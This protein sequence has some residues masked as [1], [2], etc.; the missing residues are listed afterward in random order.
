MGAPHKHRCFSRE[1]NLE[2]VHLAQESG[3]NKVDV[4]RQLGIS[5]KLRSRWTRDHRLAP[6]QAFPGHSKL[7]ERD[8]QIDYLQ[9]EN[10]QLKSELAFFRIVS[11]YFA[12]I[13]P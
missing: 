1:C 11:A 6:K 7:K 10:A 3:H 12:K 5:A 13:P 8:R 4:V 9:R 2:A